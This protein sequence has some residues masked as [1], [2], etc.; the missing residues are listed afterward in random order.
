MIQKV[1][2]KYLG[3]LSFEDLSVSFETVRNRTNS[4]TIVGCARNVYKVVTRVVYLTKET[5]I[6]FTFST[7]VMVNNISNTIVICTETKPDQNDI[8]VT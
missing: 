5:K 7:F 3:F 4:D 2:I 1:L 6:C 8:L